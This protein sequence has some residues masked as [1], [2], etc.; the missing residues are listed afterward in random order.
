MTLGFELAR[1]FLTV[2][3]SSPGFQTISIIV[4]NSQG[5]GPIGSSFL[6][7]S[8]TINNQGIYTRKT[9]AGHGVSRNLDGP[10]REIRDSERKSSYSSRHGGCGNLL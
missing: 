9:C 5:G 10:P 7:I 8:V 6:R 2:F 4:L 3:S 1:F